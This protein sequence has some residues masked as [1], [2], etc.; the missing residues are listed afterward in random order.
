M[1]F[2][3]FGMVSSGR[4]QPLKSYTLAEQQALASKTLRK[5]LAFLLGEY[6]FEARYADHP[7]DK[8]SIDSGGVV[9]APAELQAGVRYNVFWNYDGESGSDIAW[10]FRGDGGLPDSIL[11]MEESMADDHTIGIP[12]S[13]LQMAASTWTQVFYDM[14]VNY[15]I[16]G[17][18]VKPVEPRPQHDPEHEDYQPNNAPMVAEK[19]NSIFARVKADKYDVECMFVHSSQGCLAPA[20]TCPFKHTPRRDHLPS[21]GGMAACMPEGFEFMDPY[22]YFLMMDSD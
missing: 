16:Y 8:I 18:V 4:G 17:S 19:W 20:G 1:M 21:D 14:M 6:R 12:G 2:S 13:L 3:P 7:D 22:Q 10:K 9:L 15:E 11:T 5:V